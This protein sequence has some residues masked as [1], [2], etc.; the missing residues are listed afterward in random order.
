MKT[1][2]SVALLLLGVGL[3]GCRYQV[4][5]SI[6]Q[7]DLNE[8]NTKVYGK[9]KDSAAAQLSRKYPD[10]PDATQQAEGFRQ[11]WFPAGGAAG[12]E[13]ATTDTTA[14]AAQ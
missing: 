11:Q 2:L 12:A 14:A 3:A 9:S 6:N 7:P 1:K 10:N 8:H 5:N 4:N 13:A